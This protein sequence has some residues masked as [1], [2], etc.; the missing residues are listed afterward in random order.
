MAWLER[1]RWRTHE[2]MRPFSYE[3]TSCSVRMSAVSIYS[4][5]ICSSYFSPALQRLASFTIGTKNSSMALLCHYIAY[6]MCRY[7]KKQDLMPLYR[8]SWFPFLGDIAPQFCALFFLMALSEWIQTLVLIHFK[9]HTLSF[10]FL[11]KTKLCSICRKL[12]PHF[13]TFNFP[14]LKFMGEKEKQ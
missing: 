5:F 12:K 8:G 3:D 4:Y 9:E 6:T 11:V 7:L 1:V 13:F 10:Y 14:K 2:I